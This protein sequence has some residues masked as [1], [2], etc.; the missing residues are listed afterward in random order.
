MNWLVVNDSYFFVV[1]PTIKFVHS[2]WKSS[3]PLHDWKMSRFLTHEEEVR[4]RTMAESITC[5]PLHWFS[6]SRWWERNSLFLTLMALFGVRFVSRSVFI[7]T[8]GGSCF[9]KARSCLSLWRQIR[10]LI[11]SATAVVG[12]GVPI[13]MLL[14]IVQ[15]GTIDSRQTVVYVQDR[16][17]INHW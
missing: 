14:V 16:V 4:K 11:E 2:A 7:Q 12:N 10:D 9:E 17:H 8:G 1:I 5:C 15:Y 6:L 13:I 3:T